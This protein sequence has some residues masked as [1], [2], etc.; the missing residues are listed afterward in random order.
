MNASRTTSAPQASIVFDLPRD[1]PAPVTPRYRRGRDSLAV[2]ASVAAALGERAARAGCLATTGW[3]AALGVALSRYADQRH[4]PLDLIVTGA[5]HDEPARVRVTLDVAPEA[6]ADA[7]LRATA[8]ALGQ[9]TAAIAGHAPVTVSF[10]GLPTE[11]DEAALSDAMLDEAEELFV[12]SELNFTLDGRDGT[13]SLVCEYDE[14]RF[15]AATIAG[16]L[17]SWLGAARALPEAAQTPVGR[18]PLWSASALAAWRAALRGPVAE[19]PALTFSALIRTAAAHWPDAVAVETAAERL[20][21]RELLQRA[22]RV[23][24]G[25]RA[26]GVRPGEHVAVCLERRV[27]LVSALLGVMTAGCVYVPLD[28][29]YPSARRDYI[30]ENADVRLVLGETAEHDATPRAQ[31]SLDALLRDAAEGDAW[32]GDD[33]PD[34]IAY[35]IYT[36]GSTGQPKG[37]RVGNRAA[38]NLLLAMLER[39]GLQAGETWFA[40]T[41]PMFDIAFAELFAPL[42][43]GG[44]V[45]LASRDETADPLALANRIETV[46][47]RV[48]QATPA[49]WRMLVATHWQGRPDLIAVSGGEALD[50]SLARALRPRVA[51]LCN[52][53]GP[54]EAT[55]WATWH[56]VREQ[57]FVLL[58]EPLRNVA[59][60]VLDAHGAP[61]PPG[62]AGEL[63]IAGAGLAHGYHG[64]DS[65]TRERFVELTLDG[66]PPVRVYRTGDLVRAS[67]SGAVRWLARLDNQVKLRGFRIELGDIEAALNA[68]P[69]VR[70]AVAVVERLDEHDQ[71]L[72]AYIVQEDGAAGGPAAGDLS[73]RLRDS[74]R[75]TLPDYMMP[76]LFVT[77]DRM[78]LTDNG[79][80]DRGALAAL[81][82]PAPAVSGAAASVADG[83][84]LERVQAIWR[85][86]L[87]RQDV[88]VDVNFFDL[89]GHSMLLLQMQLKVEQAFGVR[90][91]RVDFFRNPT[92][93]RLA[94]YLEA[95]GEPAGDAAQP[96]GRAGRATPARATSVAVVGIGVRVPGASD[97][98]AFWRN[99][100]DGVESRTEFTE[101]E[102]REAGVP[103]ALIADPN[104][105]R[106][107]FVLDDIEQFDA[108]FFGMSPRE[109]ELLDPQ[110]RI[111]LECAWQAL[112][113]AGIDP[114]QDGDGIGVYVGTDASGYHASILA[115]LEADS[116]PAAAFQ[117]RIGNE[118]DHLPT[119]VSYRLNLRGPS[120]NVQTACSTSLVAV[121]LAAQSLLRGECDAVLAGGVCVHVPHRVGYLYQEGMV[122]S[123]DGHCRAFD[124]QGG[125]TVFGSGAGVVVLKRLDDAIAA[126]DRIYAVVKGTAVNNDGSGKVGYTAPSV[127]GQADAIMAAHAAAGVDPRAIGYVEAH[128]TATPLGDP[129]EIA[130]LTQA[131]RAATADTGFCAIGSVKTNIGHLDQAAGVAGLIKAVLAVHHGEIPPSLHCTE[132]N[133]DIPFDTSPFFV[134]TQLRPWCPEGGVRIAGVSSFGIGGTNAHAIL[135]AAPEV[136]REARPAGRG[137]QVLTLSARS[138]AALRAQA[139]N[140]AAFIERSDADLASVCYTAN[141]GRSAFEQRAAWVVRE[142]GE[143]VTRLRDFGAGGALPALMRGVYR[144]RRPRV[145]MLFTGQGAQYAGMGREL[146]EREPVFRAALDA[147]AELLKDELE[148][149]LLDV[150]YG[151]STAL[152][153]R[154]DY[155]QPALFA[156]G[157]ALRVTWESWG[158]TPQVVMGHSLGEYMAAQAAGVLT[159]EGGLKL[160]AQRGRLMQ[161]LCEGGSMLSVSLDEQTLRERLS[162]EGA[163]EGVIAAL[164]GPLQQVVAGRAE[165]IDALQAKLEQDGIHTD[166]LPGSHAFHSP[167][168]DPMLDAYRA[169]LES[170]LLSA[171]RVALVSNVSGALAGAEVGTPAYWLKHTRQAVR[172]GQGIEALAAQGVDVLLEI[173][174]RPTLVALARQ[175]LGPDS[176][177]VSL[178]SLRSGKGDVQQMLE[179]AAALHVRGAALD[180][181]AL[182]ALDRPVKIGLPTY[183]FQRKRYW[184][185]RNEGTGAHTPRRAAHDE[186][187]LHTLLGR[188][189]KLPR[190]TEVRFEAE[191]RPDWPAYVDHHRLFGAMVVP[192]ASH[193]AMFLAAAEVYYGETG[194]VVDEILFLRPFVMPEAGQRTVQIVMRPAAGQ[195]HTIDMMTLAP[196]RDPADD[197]AWTLHVEARGIRGPRA[198][199]PPPDASELG[200]VKAR[201]ADYLSGADFYSKVW[202]P[203]M[204]TGNSFRWIDEIWRGEAEALCRTRLPAL[205][206]PI[207]GPFHAGLVESGFQLLNSCWQFATDELL[208]TD[209]IYVP[210]SIDSYRLYGR[211]ETDRLWVHARIIR[212]GEGEENGVTADIRVFEDTGRVIAH[213]RGFE[214]RRLHRGAVHALLQD[215]G[216]DRL[217]ATQ[218]R[219]IDAPAATPLPADDA[220]LIVGDGA[221]A[222]AALAARLRAERVRCV[223]VVPAQTIDDD[224][225]VPLADATSESA[226][227]DTLRAVSARMGNGTLHIVDLCALD[228]VGRH[229]A[230][231]EPMAIQSRL[232]GGALALV[233]ALADAGRTARL[234]FVTRG[235]Q[236][237]GGALTVARAA[238]ATLTGLARVIATEYPEWR[239]RTIDLDPEAADPVAA[240]AP[241]LNLDG[242]EPQLALRAGAVQAARV[243]RAKPARR[244]VAPLE[245]NA[246]YVISGGLGGLGLR[247]AQQLAQAGV[248]R[249]VLLARR[250]PD[251]T[252]QAA[253]DALRAHGCAVDLARCD[254][255][256]LD[257]LRVVWNEVVLAGALPL[258]GIFHAAGALRDGVL[259]R[260]P[261]SEFVVPL[262][263]KVQGAFNLHTLSLDAELDCFVCFSS[264]S[265]L[266]GTAGQGNYAAANAYLDALAGAR[267]ALGLPATSIQWGPFAEVGMT[268]ALERA[269]REKAAA[270]GLQMLPPAELLK[271]IDAAR[272][273]DTAT[274]VAGN[275]D[276]QRYAQT[277]SSEAVLALLADWR[278]KET[279]DASPSAARDVRERFDA[280]PMPALHDVLMTYLQAHIA[281][282]LGRSPDEVAP[283]R[284][285]LELGLDSLAA[286][287]FRSQVQRDLRLSLPATFAFD[288]GNVELGADYLF[289]RLK[290]E[291]ARADAPATPSREAGATVGDKTAADDL[292][293]ELARLEA[294]LRR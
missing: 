212:Q 8:D 210:F 68:I 19:I 230:P 106:A 271:Q 246:T 1:Y 215:D 279:A 189:V 264:I 136:A 76:A 263:A 74:L 183:P 192:G 293:A 28:P 248:K 219:R 99:L 155:T 193:I 184:V 290:A 243:T 12:D 50:E 140:Y 71:R 241:L 120:I 235:A 222:G 58:G 161:R 35:L 276:W 286:V 182:H 128:G 287:E 5:G 133:P 163:T 101:T 245:P 181:A 15:E 96:R 190:S 121:H 13:L 205:L 208:K 72:V 43:A 30:L 113:D 187:G 207:D 86:V 167:L 89:G 10:S 260:Q 179:S 53:Y 265:V 47:P 269:H 202:I 158:V 144:N 14:E 88:G 255:A 137:V 124:R 123:P 170:T 259:G 24:R 174:P 175:T 237:L 27:D 60:H 227:R 201:C 228:L 3:L 131:F 21:Y 135:E 146:Y 218:W 122:A 159:L 18:L 110:Q 102:L 4:L 224:T 223:R 61:V 238:Q 194:C 252:A 38:V 49:T 240:L 196:R 63:C 66:E 108:G 249:L 231:A 84:T 291:R 33:D 94:A 204:D 51:R 262:Q 105:V 157:Y 177:Q 100:R 41:T 256:D 226:W 103:P 278:P 156:L 56:E 40:V 216:P 111:F 22:A 117:I 288:Y 92:V 169:S 258:K 129:I 257:A 2:P 209:Y 289:E 220:V 164:N 109:A 261:W 242:Y 199:P 48:L 176:E 142:S 217:F 32:A 83:T 221:G 80:L 151:E 11:P 283:T 171:P 45:W 98:E 267:R 54:T 59:L 44:R 214:V 253:I 7:L 152:L 70:Q 153:D 282:M 239:C 229:D 85:D 195:A 91:P 173:G 280:T 134:N 254:V 42:V 188:R 141:T 95:R 266:F 65:L 191:F 150:M 138:E 200:A 281:S 34:A 147:C 23:A 78:P 185:E 116:A 225:H 119:R 180:W 154:T 236:D 213:V 203:G 73:A 162:G 294:S 87:R 178:A 16:V 20:T 127:D 284:G 172:F 268:A 79:K 26:R 55:V 82:R 64:R 114:H 93:A 104:Y 272:R 37:V 9:R 198:L 244:T 115:P 186:A 81:E 118:K 292:D 125:G 77:L 277:E 247:L 57:G 168:V 197:S 52:V 251:A 232:C 97:A 233:A 36:S 130:A 165:A 90:V 62:V 107:G 25:L 143:L 206:E 75:R 270:R 46:R 148:T 6:P 112:E 234:D 67:A 285:F 31:V 17:A 160:V 69:G 145:A 39:T 29:G 274:V 273:V 149:G 166:R 211:P 275:D 250:A 132:T 126:G 139:T